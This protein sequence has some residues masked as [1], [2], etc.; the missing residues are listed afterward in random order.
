MIRRILSLGT[1][2]VMTLTTLGAQLVDF[3]EAMRNTHVAKHF[4]Q[5]YEKEREKFNF[6]ESL[7]KKNSLLYRSAITDN[8]IPCI[9]HFIWLGGALPDKYKPFIESA[10]ELHP[11]WE[12][13]LWTDETVKNLKLMNQ[14]LFDATANY[15]EKADIL[16]IELLFMY[17]GTYFDVDVKCIK[18][19]GNLRR[20]SFYA[21]L[22][23]ITNHLGLVNNGVI[24]ATQ[25]HPVLKRYLEL[26]RTNAHREHVVYRT[27]PLVFTQAIKETLFDQPAEAERMIVFPASFFSPFG[28]GQ[29]VDPAQ[30]AQFIRPETMAI[31][32]YH[33]TWTKQPGAKK[34]EICKGEKK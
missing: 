17:G 14:E 28:K 4:Q 33:G 31:H 1:L 30:E 18:P 3:H 26:M 22:G 21:G 27:G 23:P 34:K 32:Y 8:P 20:Y 11:G 29:V 9:I 13:I 12:I 2:S 10:K 16:R 6:F 25:G 5:A 7:Y 15:G 19:F 24:G